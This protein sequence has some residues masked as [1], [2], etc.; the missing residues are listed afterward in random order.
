MNALRERLP[1]R[2]NSEFFHFVYEG[3]RYVASISR[4]N[5]GRIG[6]LFLSCG[7]AGTAVSINAEAAAILCSLA[8]QAG[9]TVETIRN[10]VRGPVSAALDHLS[11]QK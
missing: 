2:R 5:D 6:E 7:K 10:A 1:S 3:H 4:F 11:G 9:I 8:L